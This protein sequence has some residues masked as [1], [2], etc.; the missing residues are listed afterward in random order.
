LPPFFLQFNFPLLPPSFLVFVFFALVF[1]FSFFVCF[2]FVFF[3]LLYFFSSIFFFLVF[4]VLFSPAVSFRFVSNQCQQSRV[5]CLHACVTRTTGCT[6]ACMHECMED[7]LIIPPDQNND[8]EEIRE[9]RT[10]RPSLSLNS[11]VI[12]GAMTHD[13]L[14]DFNFGAP[15][16]FEF[17]PEFLEVTLEGS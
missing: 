4:P 15:I 12:F 9:I 2:Y 6:N 11:T 8:S 16:A 10:L 17:F 3:T 1:L 7:E 14:V 5:C 13:H